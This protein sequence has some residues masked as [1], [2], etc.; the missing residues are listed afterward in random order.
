MTR[1]GRQTPPKLGL[2]SLALAAAMSLLLAA[3]AASA[4]VRVKDIARI[5][6]VRRNQLIGYGLVV[7]LNGTGDGSGADFTAQTASNLLERFGISV[8]AKDMKLKNVAAV[9]VTA[10][11]TP[12]SRA[13]QRMDVTVSSLGD[14]KSLTGG[15]LLLTPL[16]APNG[17]VFAVAQ[18]ALIVGGYS[19]SAEGS[20]VQ[21]NHPTVGRVPDGA[22][23]ERDAPL[24]DF[25]NGT[26]DLVL[27]KP[28]FTTANRVSE[29]LT[30]AL[31]AG[32]AQAL[33]PAR[34]RIR[35]P[36]ERATDPMAFLSTLE[37]VQVEPDAVAKVVLDEKTGTV[38]LGENVKIRPV[39]ISRGNL[40]VQVTP[41]MEVSQPGAFTGGGGALGGVGGARTVARDRADVQ[42]AEGTGQVV[43]FEP[44]ESLA[45]LVQALNILGVSPR[46]LVAIFQTLKAAGALQAELEVL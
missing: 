15:T 29:A 19:A 34:I 14:A 3:G 10:V 20:D 42:V 13:G 31:G 1:H 33:D 27:T 9:I 39:A 41:Y 35:I 12:F 44:G 4:S 26:V 2:R 30:V 45:S 5:D 6:G 11:L 37:R 18:G 16:R 28:D 21:K 7:G 22:L 32:V 40:T 23:L 46:D 24:P 43:L 17:D 8:A 25:H 36:E 38:V